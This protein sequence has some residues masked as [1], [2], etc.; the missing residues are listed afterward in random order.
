M[1][2]LDALRAI[3]D[4]D[5]EPEPEGCQCEQSLQA[6]CD[7]LAKSVMDLQDENASLKKADQDAWML[8]EEVLQA[9][10]LE[11]AKRLAS[12]YLGLEQPW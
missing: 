12:V 11:E 3:V 4:T 1:T 6:T 10:T 5:Q 9:A 7:R 8:A 2:R